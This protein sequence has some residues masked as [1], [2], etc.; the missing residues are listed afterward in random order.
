MIN[1][2]LIIIT[3]MHARYLIIMHTK[4]INDK[5]TGNGIKMHYYLLAKLQI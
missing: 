2:T 1:T 4:N 5:L 3:S